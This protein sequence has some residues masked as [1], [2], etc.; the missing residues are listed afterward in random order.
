M[1]GERSRPPF[2][3]D[4]RQTSIIPAAY[5]WPSLLARHG[6]RGAVVA[7]V[8]TIRGKGTFD[9]FDLLPTA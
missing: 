4:S 2:V 7:R 9:G 8:D 6:P 1:A 5:A 3:F